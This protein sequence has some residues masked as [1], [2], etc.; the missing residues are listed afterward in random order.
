MFSESSSF[1]DP[2][3]ATM[4]NYEDEAAQ[5]HARINKLRPA[6]TTMLDVAC[7]TGE[8]AKH[9]KAYFQI[10]GVDLNPEF[11]KTAQSKNPEGFYKVAD[12]TDFDMAKKYDV[13][14]CL[15]SSIGYVGTSERLKKT[16]RCFAKHLNHDGII[17]VEPWLT[18]ES[19]VQ[20]RLHMV[21]VSEDELRIC[22]MNISETKAKGQSF[23]RFH[24][25]VGTP[26]GV[27]HFTEDHTFGLFTVNEM[28]QAFNEAG[29]VVD[30]DERG[31]FGRGLYIAERA[32]A[33]DNRR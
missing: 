3:Y 11:L 4:K 29:L 27:S 16:V 19:W 17:I 20:G 6:A 26:A 7:G 15:F 32:A 10:D 24:Y 5:I 18:P 23:F 25:L 14:I 33:P 13:L 12:M 28:K 30:Y 9:L 21:S 1:Y 8:H 22:R 2:I 31:I